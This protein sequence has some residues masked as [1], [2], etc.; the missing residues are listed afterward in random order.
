MS[1]WLI[2]TLFH[3]S[4]TKL[5]PFDDEQYSVVRKGPF[6][7]PDHSASES[8]QHYDA[9]AASPP[10]AKP[11]RDPS[12]SKDSRESFAG[13]TGLSELDNLLAM[14]TDTQQTIQKGQFSDWS[15]TDIKK[16]MECVVLL[17]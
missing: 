1:V 12:E 7:S 2:T 9:V 15:S 4:Y 10:P 17:H 6:Y 14:L 11:P 3:R 16:N 8:P 13:S 5:Q